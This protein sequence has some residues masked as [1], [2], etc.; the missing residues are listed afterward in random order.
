M[1]KEF[2]ASRWRVLA[3]PEVQ[4]ILAKTGK[5]KTTCEKSKK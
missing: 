1:L 3:K 5:R 4:E 2:A